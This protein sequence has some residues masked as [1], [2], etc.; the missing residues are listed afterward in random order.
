MER[1]QPQGEGVL[2][3]I[4]KALSHVTTDILDGA[5]STAVGDQL[6]LDSF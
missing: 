3:D 2:G 4:Q 5:F 1:F 6:D